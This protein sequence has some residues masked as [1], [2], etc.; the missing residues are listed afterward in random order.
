MYV[1]RRRCN[2]IP[3]YLTLLILSWCKLCLEL[4]LDISFSTDKEDFEPAVIQ[5][6]SS[7][8]FNV[9]YLLSL[10]LSRHQILTLLQPFQVR[11]LLQ[12]QL[13]AKN[14]FCNPSL[15][16]TN[17]EYFAHYNVNVQQ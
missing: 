13:L 12:I 10:S 5:G 9:S 4:E 17:I 8:F 1:A 16:K 6:K 7:D 2:T 14:T 11:E 15:R 3:Y